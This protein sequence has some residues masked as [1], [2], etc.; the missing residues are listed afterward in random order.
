MAKSFSPA[1]MT[2]NDLLDGDAVWWTGAAWSRD[3]AEAAIAETP[4]ARDA[5]TALSTSPSHD[6]EVVG[7]Y[8]V[9]IALVDGRVTPTVRREAIRADREPTFAYAGAPAR[10]REAA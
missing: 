6:A 10:V 5:L 2:A 9:D 3:I 8:L 4:E 1:L 7:P